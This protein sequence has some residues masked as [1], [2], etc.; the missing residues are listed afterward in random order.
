MSPVHVTLAPPA[1]CHQG[2][3]ERTT[4]NLGGGGY[5]TK[6]QEFC[7]AFAEYRG[8]LRMN[9]LVSNFAGNI[10]HFLVCVDQY[11]Y[12]LPFEV[13]PQSCT[14]DHCSSHRPLVDKY[15]VYIVLFFF[16]GFCWQCICYFLSCELSWDMSIINLHQRLVNYTSPAVVVQEKPN[17]L[18][19]CMKA[20][21]GKRS[22]W[23]EWSAH[24]VLAAG[25]SLVPRWSWGVWL[26]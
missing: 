25:G 12:S 1:I 24:Q 3:P 19:K 5:R 17:R 18:E 11:Q 4:G 26:L 21:L 22:S 23:S 8:E 16:T 9:A 7:E 13:P 14:C 15:T 6:C 20:G 10:T 2:G